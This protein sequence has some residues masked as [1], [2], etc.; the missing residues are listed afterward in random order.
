MSSMKKKTTSTASRRLI[1]VDREGM[2]KMTGREQGWW[3][4]V[5]H[6]HYF[7]LRFRP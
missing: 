7:A 5:I 4:R 2:A 1:F 6:Y 3:Y